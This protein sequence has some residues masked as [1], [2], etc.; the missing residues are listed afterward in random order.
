[1]KGILQ[2]CDTEDGTYKNVGTVRARKNQDYKIEAITAKNRIEEV[3]ELACRVYVRALCLELN[4][5]FLD[6]DEWFFRV[7][8]FDDLK[9]V[10]LGEH[11]YTVD[12]DGLLKVHEIEYHTVEISF[13]IEFDE[14]DYYSDGEPLPEDEGGIVIED[15]DIYIE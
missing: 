12:Y 6:Q 3:E 2:Y 8:Y 7:A 5:D 1:M 11:P 14:Y 15:D 10:K 4:T 9:M 13:T